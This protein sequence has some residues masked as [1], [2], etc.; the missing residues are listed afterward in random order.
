MKRESQ[1][2]GV[3]KNGAKQPVFPAQPTPDQLVVAMRQA[4]QRIRR[5]SHRQRVQ[6]LKE[7]GIL[8]TAGKLSAC[9]K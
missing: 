4:V 6:S 9:Y 7:A 3:K 2:V 1:T 5:M 8:T